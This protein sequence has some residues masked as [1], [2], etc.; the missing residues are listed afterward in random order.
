VRLVPAARRFARSG[1]LGAAGVLAVGIVWWLAARQLGAV[2]LP[3]P[4][5]VL[6]TLRDDFDNIPAL[7]YVSFQSGGIK[8]AVLHTAGN[9]AIGVAIGTAVGFPLGAI[10]GRSRI[11]REILA[12]PMLVLS[13]IPVLIVLP[14]LAIW[15]GTSRFVQEGLVIM[16]ALVTVAVVAQNATMDVA[17]RFTQYAASLGATRWTMLRE[18]IL[19]AVVPPVIGAVRVATSAGWSFAALSELL[20]GNA[21]TGRLIQTMQGMSATADIMAT[22]LA[23]GVLAVL[24][25][26]AVAGVGRWLVRWQE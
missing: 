13:T 19:P 15:F 23:L 12:P 16:F 7:L 8:D 2:R 5:E 1:V 22:I 18:V 17:G 24:V 4:I 14:F 21:G 20:A 10:L 3:G 6:R 11:T 9:V 25:D 26:T